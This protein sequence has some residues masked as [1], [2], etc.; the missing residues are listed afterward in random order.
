MLYLLYVNDIHHSCNSNI[1]SFADDTTIF[2]SH[3]NI[4]SLFELGNKDLNDSYT[5]F[6]ANRLSLNVGNTKY[7]LI[8]PRQR[9]CDCS[10]LSM[11]I[12]NTKLMRIGMDCNEQAN[13]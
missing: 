4:M 13:K 1:L 11:S 7:I 12:H 5:W 6:C 10:G 8:K 9:Q 2:S 3:S